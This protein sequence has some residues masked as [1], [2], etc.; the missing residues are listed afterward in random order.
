MIKLKS[1]NLKAVEYNKIQKTLIVKFKSGLSYIY[2]DVP[3][4]IYTNLLNA[5]SKGKYFH[6]HIKGVYGYSKIG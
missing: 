1:T 4:E 5:E 6:T 3:N 2:F